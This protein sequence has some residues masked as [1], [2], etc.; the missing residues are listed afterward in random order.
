VRKSVGKFQKSITYWLSIIL[1]CFFH[2]WK[3]DYD[4]FK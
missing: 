3:D 1:I 4:T 2:F